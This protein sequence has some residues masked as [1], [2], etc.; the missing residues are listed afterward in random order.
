[1]PERID[2]ALA[3]RAKAQRLRQIAG[4]NPQLAPELLAMAHELEEEA[5][6]LEIAA[7]RDLGKT[8]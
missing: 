5:R 7:I 6:K 1:M 2:T 8:A 3:L 4:G